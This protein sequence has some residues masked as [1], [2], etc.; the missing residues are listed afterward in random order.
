MWLNENKET[1]SFVQIYKKKTFFLFDMSTWRYLLFG[2][3]YFLMH[4]KRINKC[5]WLF[6]DANSH[7][8]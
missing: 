1:R 5:L 7:Q 8:K 4:I 6:S 2:Y 3:K